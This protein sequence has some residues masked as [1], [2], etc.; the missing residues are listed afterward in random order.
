[1]SKSKL[2]ILFLAAEARPFVTVGGLGEVTYSLIRALGSLPKNITGLDELDIRLALPFYAAID[3]EKYDLQPIVDF[4]VPYKASSIKAKAF[5]VHVDGIPVYLIHGSPITKESG[6]IYSPNAA[7]DGKKF[8]FY[9]LA[10]LELART[11]QWQP[12][13][14]HA[15]DWH[16][17]PAIYSLYIRRK[18]D[19]FFSNTAT[20]LGIH[21]L[22]Y[23]GIGAGP[24]LNDFGLP[25]A[26]G[27]NLPFWAQNLPFPL[28]LLAADHIVAVSPGY[29]QE[30][31]TPEF[32]SGLDKFL[33][34]RASIIT[35]IL[36]GIDIVYWDP[37]TDPLI[38]F[39][40]F[41]GKIEHRKGNKLWLQRKLGLDTN[42]SIPILGM[43]GR[44]DN[45]KGVDLIMDA[46]LKLIDHPWQAILLGTGQPELE[47]AA[48]R[49]QATL[50]NRV[51]AVIA[52]DKALSRDIYAG[53]DAVLIPSRYE[54]CG[55]VQMIA[56]RYGCIP[57][58][59]A[60]GGLKD[61]IKDFDQIS[62]STGFLFK[63]ASSK[64]L[65]KA[66]ARALEV[67]SDPDQWL[68]LQKRAIAEDFSWERSAIEYL[69][70]YKSLT[71]RP[72]KKSW[73]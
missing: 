7:L 36:N 21:N 8:V 13:V 69:K 66:I 42:P 52:Y 46:L 2:K 40:Y 26:H 54:P 57:I 17:A 3:E 61:T 68:M 56:M 5:E 60:T 14:V 29:A 4:I 48:R 62:N 59:R 33:K 37:E 72:V 23:L 58:A 50:P 39:N 19:N 31:L 71:K 27:S 32:G 53:C 16:T 70:L 1:M 63:K 25:P 18:S 24:A 64:A 10:A 11:L 6:P 30:I 45:Q 41:E 67:Y 49:L 73:S 43:V 65:A 12:D 35:G 47:N 9:S 34:S 28:G 15:N 20:L 38:Q 55:L 22:P 51:R 44:L